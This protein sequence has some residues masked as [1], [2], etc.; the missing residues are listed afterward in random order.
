MFKLAR[1]GFNR[2]GVGLSRLV[3]NEVRKIE[4][5]TLEWQNDDGMASVS[6]FGVTNL[7]QG[8]R[9]RSN[10]ESASVVQIIFISSTN[11]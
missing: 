9:S 3:G 6:A 7:S 4:L 1:L 11:P 5:E 10:T 8:K 2:N